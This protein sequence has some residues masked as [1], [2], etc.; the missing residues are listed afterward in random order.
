[1]KNLTYAAATLA[2]LFTVL[3]ARFLWPSVKLLYQVFEDAFAQQQAPEKTKD[4]QVVIADEGTVK[5]GASV[6]STKTSA[7]AEDVTTVITATSTTPKRTTRRR[8]TTK[9]TKSRTASN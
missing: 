2:A 9:Q 8:T 7:L 3:I 6:S 5:A 1:M 4:I